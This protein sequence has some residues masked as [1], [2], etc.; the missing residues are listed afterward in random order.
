MNHLEYLPELFKETVDLVDGVVTG[1][2]CLNSF[3]GIGSP[4]TDMKL[5]ASG[6]P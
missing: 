4:Y 2:C 3:M 1:K 6:K 5:R